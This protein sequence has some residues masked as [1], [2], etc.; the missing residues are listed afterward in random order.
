MTA[1]NSSEKWN[2]LVAEMEPSILVLVGKLMNQN[3]PKTTIFRE[4]FKL[5]INAKTA[6][7][8]VTTKKS[9]QQCT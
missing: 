8:W 5:V 7:V 3:V 4:G 9:R 6:N 2:Y 1:L